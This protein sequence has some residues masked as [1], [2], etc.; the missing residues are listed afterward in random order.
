MRRFHLG[1]LW[2]FFIVLGL[3][4]LGSLAI[5]S[6]VHMRQVKQERLE[7]VDRQLRQAALALQFGIS[8][9]SLRALPLEEGEASAVLN[10]TYRSLASRIREYQR[11][12]NKENTLIPIKTISVLRLENNQARVIFSTSRAL[13][14][15]SQQTLPPSVLLRVKQGQIE[16]YHHAGNPGPQ[17]SAYVP[18]VDGLNN[19][20][21]VARLDVDPA[22]LAQQL[23]SAWGMMFR[24]LAPGLLLAFLASFVLSRMVTRPID[25]YVAFVN[26]VSE[27]NYHLRSDMHTYDELEKIGQA[28]NVMLEKLEGLIETEADRDRLQQQITSLLRIVSAAA[29]GDFTVRAE[30]TADTLGALADS[31]NLMVA[32][33]SRLVHDV[34]AAS[35]Q[36]SKSTR[37]VLLTTE[38]MAQGAETQA[39]EIEATYKAAREMADI[40]KYANDRTLQAAKSAQRAAEVAQKGSLVVKKS[41]EG[42]H[43]IRETVQET[44]RRVRLLGESSS[45]IGEIIEVISEIANRTNL[46]ALNATIEAARAGD[47]GRG[48]AVVADEV[49]ILAERSSQAAKDIAV[50]IESI[51]VGTSEAVQAM[52]HGTQEVEKGTKLVDEAGTSLK[53]IL[54]MVQVSSRSI[55]EISGAFQQQTKA[56][57]GIVKAMERIATIAQQTAKGARKSRLLAEQMERLSRALHVAV[58][59]FRL[60]E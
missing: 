5:L 43:R 30:V 53:Q 33:L 2:K 28:L 6:A 39:K 57:S 55:T 10:P 54:E 36:I 11:W 59:K 25:R 44:T 18:I 46:L 60:P 56:S 13:K 49:R 4:S 15:L 31:F 47:A 45:E 8:G 51:Q 17:S 21:A 12:L 50:L 22:A 52:E 7:A 24:Y 1:L 29:D 9:D 14:F 48:F 34:K 35:D 19:V 41:I 26:Q 58:A 23:P 32:E 40:I 38:V 37:E 20:V 27:G 42:M 16:L 3:L